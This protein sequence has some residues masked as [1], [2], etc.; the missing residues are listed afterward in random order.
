MGENQPPHS[1]SLYNDVSH[2]TRDLQIIREKISHYTVIACIAMFLIKHVIYKLY[3][4][5]SV[6][7]Q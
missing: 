4:K 1:N 2:K 5:K 3:G 6:T 7:T